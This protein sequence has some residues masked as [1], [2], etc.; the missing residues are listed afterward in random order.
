MEAFGS[1]GSRAVGYPGHEQAGEYIQ[2]VFNELGLKDL[3]VDPV[4]RAA[5]IDEGASLK[6]GGQTVPLACFWPNLVRTVATPPQGISGKLFYAGQGHPED[7]RGVDLSECIVIL[8]L[9]SGDRFIMARSLGARAI[10]FIEPD[11]PERGHMIGK[12]L[13][14]PVSIPRYWLSKQAW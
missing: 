10:L 5:P 12:I 3:Q 9:D 2:K 8:D 13:D 7:Y 4:V 1:V 14:S 6:V 11:Q